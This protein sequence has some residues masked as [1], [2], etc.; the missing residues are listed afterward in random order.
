MSDT[1]NVKLGVCSIF[2]KGVDLGYTK[3]GVDVEVTTSTHPVNVDQFG[4]SVVNEYITKRDIKVSVPL[5]ET[6]LENMV[7]IMPGATLTSNGTK[8]TGT[9]TFSGNP[10]ANDTITVNGK[11]FTFKATDTAETDILIGSTAA[12]TIVNA[13]AKLNAS[14]LA[15]VLKGKYTATSATVLTVDYDVEGTVGNAFTLAKS[16]T[17]VTVS[18]ATLASGTNATK[19]RVD[20]TNGVGTNLLNI[21]GALTLHP[22]ELLETDHSEDLTIPLAATPGG[23][24]FAYK[25][26]DERI[27]NTEFMGYP[28]PTTKVLFKFGDLTA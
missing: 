21:A 19:K 25:H 2:Y 9:F 13:A 27:F 22:I 7:A 18:A 6:T 26:D 17:V 14:T 16:S 5:A 24:K 23:M 10:T 3:G 20:V 1:R 11:V 8:A 28:D 4:E 12:D 15:A